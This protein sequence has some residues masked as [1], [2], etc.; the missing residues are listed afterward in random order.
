ML[1]VSRS[2]EADD[3][4]NGCLL[5]DPFRPGAM[6]QD[7]RNRDRHG[8]DNRPICDRDWAFIQRCFSRADIRRPMDEVVD[9]ISTAIIRDPT[10]LPETSSNYTGLERKRVTW[11]ASSPNFNIDG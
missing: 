3:D 5:L 8:I 7:A 11:R 9:F 1:Q 10:G 4:Y 6:G 2:S